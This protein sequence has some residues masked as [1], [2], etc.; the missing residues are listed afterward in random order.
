MFRALLRDDN[1]FLSMNI[2]L[3]RIGVVRAVE[4]PVLVRFGLLGGGVLGLL[5]GPGDHL[6]GG[7]ATR[8]VDRVR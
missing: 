4:V 8:R 6:G 5:R 3:L 1:L 7:G 2:F